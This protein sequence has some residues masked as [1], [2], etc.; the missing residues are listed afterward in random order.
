M[1]NISFLSFFLLVNLSLIAQNTKI[2]SLNNA[3]ANTIIVEEKANILL[4]LCK[5]EQKVDF[6]NSLDIRYKLLQFSIN[7]KLKKHEYEAYRY[8]SYF[9]LRKEELDS[10]KKYDQKLLE[11][12]KQ[13]D[14][15]KVVSSLLNI[16]AFYF[17]K[18][19]PDSSLIYLRKAE[20]TA[21]NN[22][23]SNNKRDSIKN[24]TYL[25]MARTSIVKSLFSKK[26]Y[27]SALEITY[28]NLTFAEKYDIHKYDFFNYYYLGMIYME[29]EKYDDAIKYYKK[30]LELTQIRKNTNGE[31]FS[32]IHLGKAYLASDEKNINIALS[33]FKKARSIF[34]KSQYHRG[35]QV[36]RKN[37]FNAY[38]VQKA[39]DKAIQIGELYVSEYK[40]KESNDPYLS[41]FYVKLGKAYL[42]NKNTKKGNTLLNKGLNYTTKAPN[43]TSISIL[44]EVYK[45]HKEL[46]N[47]KE[48]LLYFERVT[49][50][51][52]SLLSN[53]DFTKKLVES[54]TK[55]QT[56]KKEKENLQLK[57]DNA[58]Q[59]LLTQKANTR[60]WV[61]AVGLL[62]VL[63]IAFFI[64]K[65]Y[66]S[67]AKAKQTI[68]NQKEEI[69][70]Q[71]NLIEIMQRDLHHRMKN[72]LSFI[73]LFIN[74]A[75]FRFPNK[76]YQ[77][78]LDEL[79][80]R[81]HS[82]FEVHKQLFMKDDVTSVKAKSYIDKL[83]QNVKKAYDKSNIVISNNTSNDETILANTSFPVGLIVNEFVT[84][85]YKYAFDESE[86]G[87]IDISLVSDDENYHLS[88]KD[89]GK[90]LPNDFDIEDLD[91]FGME[92]IQLLTQ[93][94]KG[95]FAL[96]GSN[97]VTMK[98]TLPKIA[99]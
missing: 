66:K 8:L 69:E 79:Q 90:G 18:S 47:H 42:L 11:T 89:N 30:E 13:I 14:S 75:K 54:E 39:Y 55:F 12:A 91:S 40:N 51:K 73:D 19:Q 93:E 25:L 9:F 6:N 38:M 31:A 58:E 56:E 5:T 2:D 84:N 46:N 77:E 72:N 24:I 35:I 87:I 17:K 80:N 33:H 70:Q 1:R 15:N 34:S 60:N 21:L 92:T 4:E 10:V 65:R 37:L 96:D 85:S 61:L 67:E 45:T 76:A 53:E 26:D 16:G 3:F 88:L 27:N 74:L 48:A 97:G 83:V 98:I 81:M 32:L 44:N 59:A 62:S 7:N 68:S 50:L 99:A 63:L 94:Y 41:S 95:T 36:C 23:E 49:T 28:Q 22:I 86:N 71:K 43:E 52:D 64:W 29:L 82:M 57:A 78:K 20:Q